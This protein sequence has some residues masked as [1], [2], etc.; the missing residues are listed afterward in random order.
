MSKP[1]SYAWLTSGRH[2]GIDS[3]APAPSVDGAVAGEFPFEFIS[4]DP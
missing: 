2:D 3:E 1:M 4:W